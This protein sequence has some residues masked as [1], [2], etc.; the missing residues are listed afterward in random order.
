MTSR[1]PHPEEKLSAYADGELPA[2]EAESVEAH[3]ETCTECRRELAAIETMGDAMS[4]GDVD[5][6]RSVWDGVRRR[7]VRPAGWLLVVAGAAVLA[8]LA[9]VEWFRTGALTPEWLATTAVGVGIGLLAVNIGWE[10]Y[11][12]WKQSPY[13]DVER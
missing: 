9:A 8:A 1:N 4:A 2:P 11:R 7:I 13:R 6:R 3:L 10:Q 5:G 12:E